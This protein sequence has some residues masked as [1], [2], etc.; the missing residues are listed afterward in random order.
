MKR[1]TI[2][3]LAVLVACFLTAC[4]GTETT[5]NT[6]KEPSKVES[7]QP[8]PPATSGKKRKNSTLEP[9][10][11][12]IDQMGMYSKLSNMFK[13]RP[14]EISAQDSINIMTVAKYI[15]VIDVLDKPPMRSFKPRPGETISEIRRN[16][17]VV[18]VLHQIMADDFARR[19]RYYVRDGKIVYFVKREWDKVAN[20]P[21]ASEV[22][23]FFIDGKPVKIL[24]RS[25]ELAPGEKPIALTKYY[26]KS[27]D[28]RAAEVQAEAEAHWV[29]L[30]EYLNVE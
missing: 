27:A 26:V 24:E 4:Q 3:S 5:D 19:Y 7:A 1:S 10:D 28:H 17:E 14:E 2:V 15:Y 22:F 12:E 11:V 18:R 29:E 9:E 8:E 6:A 21:V 20:P 13:Y 16:G 23:A 25:H 30:K